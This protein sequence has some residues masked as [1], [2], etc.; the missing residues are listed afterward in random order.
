MAILILK[1]LYGF[2][3]GG[4]EKNAESFAGKAFECGRSQAPELAANQAS[5]PFY[6][7]DLLDSP[8]EPFL[9]KFYM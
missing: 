3:G 4:G 2:Q 6:Q 5:Q 7:F 9:N 1:A 8:I